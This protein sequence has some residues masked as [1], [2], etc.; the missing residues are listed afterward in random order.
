MVFISFLENC[1]LNNFS[2][3]SI[4]ILKFMC[5]RINARKGELTQ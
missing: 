3:L 1:C 4:I 5:I 2:H